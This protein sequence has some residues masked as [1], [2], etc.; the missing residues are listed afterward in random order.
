VPIPKHQILGGATL[1]DV[2]YQMVR[3]NTIA[4]FIPNTIG[5]ALNTTI[6]T[7]GSFAGPLCPFVG[8]CLT[9]PSLDRFPETAGAA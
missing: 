4:W 7:I 3:D 6:F 5:E 1:P 9:R 8:N 2:A